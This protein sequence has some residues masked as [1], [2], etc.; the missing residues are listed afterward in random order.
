MLQARMT[1][2]SDAVQDAESF[3]IL[4]PFLP[5]LRLLWGIRTEGTYDGTTY[6]GIDAAL[7]FTPRRGG[8]TS[9][10]KKLALDAARK[11][12]V[13]CERTGWGR[14]SKSIV[15]LTEEGEAQ[16]QRLFK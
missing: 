16:C 1:V 9:W 10:G 4:R 3:R 13:T 2:T 5:M 11:G 8:Q 15:R 14:G 7:G 6:D 12:L